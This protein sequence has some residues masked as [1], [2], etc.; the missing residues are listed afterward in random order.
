MARETR[1]ATGNSKPRIFDEP[2]VVPKKRVAAKPKANTTAKRSPKKTAAGSKPVGVTK[3]A[4]PKKKAVTVTKD[5]AEDNTEKKDEK[6]VEKAVEKAEAKVEKA[7]AVTADKSKKVCYYLLSLF[8]CLE[9]QMGVR[10]A[11]ACSACVVVTFVYK[12]V[13][14]SKVH[15]KLLLM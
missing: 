3:K 7:A 15:F 10:R 4:A 6:A 9:L 1:A 5:K 2:V 11:G 12:R 8:V 14:C 13:S